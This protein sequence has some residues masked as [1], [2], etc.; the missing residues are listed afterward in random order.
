MPSKENYSKFLGISIKIPKKLE[1][2]EQSMEI[3]NERY[4]GPQKRQ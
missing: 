2:E 1:F 4:I 3:P